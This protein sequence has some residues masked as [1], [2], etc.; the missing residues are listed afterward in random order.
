ML[1]WLLAFD[2]SMFASIG[3]SSGI[4][5]GASMVA[6][7]VARIVASIVANIVAGSVASIA[8]VPRSIDPQNDDRFTLQAV[9]RNGLLFSIDNRRLYCMKEM[10][11]RACCND[12]S[13]IVWCKARIHNWSP[14]FDKFLDHLDDLYICV[15]PSDLDRRFADLGTSHVAPVEMLARAWARQGTE[16][17]HGT[18]RVRAHLSDAGRLHLRSPA[19][20]AAQYADYGIVR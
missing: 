14:F 1:A 6:R 13:A 17:S 19:C 15:G 2:A 7:I 5:I 9:R 12:L 3:T 16:R 20:K 18:E 8:V 4:I 11:R 10:Q